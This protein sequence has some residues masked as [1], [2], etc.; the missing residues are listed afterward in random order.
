MGD[1]QNSE[2]PIGQRHDPKL[3]KLEQGLGG[4]A[5]LG[6]NSLVQGHLGRGQRTVREGILGSGCL[7]SSSVF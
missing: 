6:E 2:P 3:A 7:G 1:V 5:E 4:P